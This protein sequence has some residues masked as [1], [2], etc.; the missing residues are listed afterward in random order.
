MQVIHIF[1]S[2]L[3]AVQEII[4]L[5][6]FIHQI[7]EGNCRKTEDFKALVIR[8]CSDYVLW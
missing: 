4:Q 6:Y 7:I 2:K 1:V 5:N 8:S 3:C